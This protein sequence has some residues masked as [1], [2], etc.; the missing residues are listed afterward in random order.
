LFSLGQY[1]K[2]AAENREAI[3]LN[4]AAGIDFASLISNY[5][6]LNRVGDAEATVKEARSKGMD[7][8]LT[9]YGAL[10]SVAFLKN[11][12]GEM[13]RQVALVK[14]K[15]GEQ[16]SL[17]EM[18]ADTAAYSGHLRKAQQFS[19]RA[20]NFSEHAGDHETAATDTALF[21]LRNAMLGNAAV[22]SKHAALAIARSAGRDT[23]Y[24]AALAFSYAGEDRRAETLME[25]LSRQFPQDTIM[26]FHHLPTLRAHIVINR[27]K[28]ADAVDAL[29]AAAPYELSDAAAEFQK[30]LDNPGIVLNEPIGALA[31]L[32]ISR[33]YEMAGDT[34]KAKAAYQDFLTLWKDADRDIPILKQAKA[35][36]AKLQ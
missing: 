29:K 11:D 27:G 25:N 36:Y 32:Q 12:S 14:G 21:A 10:Y 22:A 19:V 5:L 2:A 17:L 3:R 13:A 18:E 24:A 28:A 33:A 31:H 7:S 23:E 26:Q 16:E 1:D 4:P 34:A 30:I 6:P 35:E 15:P 8:A 9:D 20:V